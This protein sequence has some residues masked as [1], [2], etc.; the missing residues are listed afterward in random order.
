MRFLRLL[1]VVLAMAA[2][3]ACGSKEDRRQK[4]YESAKKYQ[5]EQK[6]DEAKIALRN[7]LKIDPKF[8]EGYELMGDLMMQEKNIRQAYQSY[9]KAVEL[10]PGLIQ[11][12]LGVGRIYTLAGELDKADQAANTVLD[13]DPRNLDALLIRA[14]VL[15]RRKATGQARAILDELIKAHPKSTDVAFLMS[16]VHRLEGNDAEAVRVLREAAERVDNKDVVLVQLANIYMEK[17]QFAEAKEVYARLAAAHPEKPALRL[18]TANVLQQEGD[19]AGSIA[20]LQEVIAR[21]PTNQQYRSTLAKLHLVGKDPKS[22]EQALQAERGKALN[23]EIDVVVRQALAEGKIA[24]DAVR[25]LAESAPI[26]E[27]MWTFRPGLD[28][29]FR[30][31]IR[32]A[33]TSVSDPEALKVF[34]AE[35][36]IAASDADVDRVRGWIEAIGH[37]DVPGRPTLFGTTR[38]FLSDLG[39][40]ALSDLPPL[41]ELGTLVAPNETALIPEVRDHDAPIVFGAVIE[42]AAPCL[43]ESP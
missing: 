41:E 8:A 15:A 38:H 31:E 42:T 6:Y 40:T 2:L 37:R 23:S 22:A 14:G 29:A 28:P 30:E 24:R 36:F 35:A 10:N 17:R 18:L 16:E 1:C 9:A 20:I 12:Q 13:K 43:L 27:Y 25:I 11:A 32:K 4:F 34:R 5:S 39:L 7:A 19:F 26:P 3:V 33:F 21:E